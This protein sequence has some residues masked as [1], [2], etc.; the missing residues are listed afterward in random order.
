MLLHNKNSQ[1]GFALLMSLIVVSVV[2]SIGLSVL[3]LSLK[4]LRL[5][6][7]SKDSETSFHATNAGLECARYWR[8]LES[9]E[10]EAGDPIS[11]S[12]FGISLGTITEGPTVNVSGPGDAY[13]YS[14]Q[15]SWGGV[16]SERCSQMK[17]L[18]IVSEPTS[19]TTVTGMQTLVPGYPYG[20]T[21]ECEPGARCTVISVQGYSR[22]CSAITL[23][24][25]VQREVLLE[26]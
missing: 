2:V 15:A 25:T 17:T 18:V 11:P 12:C 22:A 4:Q 9:A 23:S 5:S 20:T 7:N 16:G 24:G 26:L 14:M 8:S 1:N 19:I 3:D 6:T 13:Q 10:M 21:K